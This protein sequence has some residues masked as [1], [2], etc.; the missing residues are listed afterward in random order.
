MEGLAVQYI[1]CIILLVME[2][3]VITSVLGEYTRIRLALVCFTCR[4]ILMSASSA[5]SVKD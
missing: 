2:S 1:L 4:H 3:D 5:R